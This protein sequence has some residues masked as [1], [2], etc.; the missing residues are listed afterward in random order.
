M[1]EKKLILSISF[2]FHDSGITLAN[3]EK[4]LIH[5]EA[6][7][8][9]REKHK[10]IETLEEVDYLVKIGLEYINKN[11][12]DVTE[13]LV[14]EWQN[15][16]AGENVKILGRRFK[17]ILTNHHENHIGVIIPSGFEK[18]VIF[19]S[20]GGSEE[21]TTKVYYKDKDEIWLAED[22]N[23]SKCTGQFYGT[24]S[25]L[26]L[27]PDFNI[28]HT[29][30]VGKLMGLSSLGNF[31][32][33]ILK[34][35]VENQE[36]LNKLYVDGCEHL[37]PLLGLKNEYDKPWEDKYKRDIA[38]VAHNYWVEENVK[39]IKKH[40][41]FSR[42]ICITGG[43]A[44][45]I[46][47]NSKL[48]DDKIFDN[49]YVSPISTD[50]GQSLGAILYRYPNIKI[51]YPFMGRGNENIETYDEKVID[52][53]IDHKIIAWFQGR[54]EIGARALGHRSFIGLPDSINMKVRVSEEIKGREP[55]R[56]VAAMLPEELISEYFYQDYESP[57]M[58][59]CAKAKEITKKIAPAIVHND[60]TTRVQTV[61]KKDNPII[62][63]ILMK[64]NK[65][66]NLP[67]LMNTSFNDSHEPIVDTVEDA[68]KTYKNSK[69]DSLY[70]D[71]K[72]FIEKDI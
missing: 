12:N 59:F 11:I 32:D 51:K 46:A 70:I 49:V 34:I 18:C 19:V 5:L 38:Y 72:K 36:K 68:I 21:G 55:Y 6:E 58:T 8:I 35:L 66:I 4:V 67:I 43:C 71:G 15:L 25:Q 10:K 17:A 69:A 20:D 28:A 23:N 52:E 61:N 9:F 62:Y 26:L 27:E 7:R 63:D 37:L 39:K 44:L 2:C 56:P 45:N 40:N 22:L 53:I 1:R 50:S 33:N 60:G 31:D 41:E 57:Y 3:E 48:L 16:Y 13:V 14:T 42:N 54:S 24:I 30:A 65:R 47:L 64:L 29:S